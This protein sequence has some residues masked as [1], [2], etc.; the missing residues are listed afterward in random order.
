MCSS[1]DFEKE[2]VYS[3]VDDN[4]E[5]SIVESRY[6]VDNGVFVPAFFIGNEFSQLIFHFPV[7]RERADIETSAGAAYGSENIAVTDCIPHGSVS[8]HT[9]PGNGSCL[10]IGY[11]T[12]VGVDVSNHFV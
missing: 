2:I 12:E 4:S 10:A 11:G 7:R 9:E 1:V 5:I 3:A 8:S 6:E